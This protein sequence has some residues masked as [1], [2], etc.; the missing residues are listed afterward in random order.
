M[1]INFIALLLSV[2][3]IKLDDSILKDQ[4]FLSLKDTTITIVQI[5]PEGRPNPFAPI[6]AENIV[7]QPEIPIEKKTDQKTPTAKKDKIT[8]KT[9]DPSGDAGST[10]P[11]T[12][13]PP[14][15]PGSDLNIDPNAG[16]PDNPDL[17]L[18]PGTEDPSGE[19]DP[20]VDP[21]TGDP[22]GPDPFDPGSFGGDPFG[23][24]TN[25]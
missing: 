8:S 14:T 9:P 22:L 15:D 2:R 21:G 12:T 17:P 19:P 5:D 10:P 3:S 6:G 16:L 13:P 24:F 20:L 1:I 7:V 23:D 25:P 4:S 18:D 11:P